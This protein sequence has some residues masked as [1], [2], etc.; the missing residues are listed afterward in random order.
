MLLFTACII[1]LAGCGKQTNIEENPPKEEVVE[2]MKEVIEEEPEPQISGNILINQIGYEPETQKLVIFRGERKELSFDVLDEKTNK[3]V[4]SDS[5]L[6]K[7]YNEKSEEYTSYGDFSKLTQTGEYYILVGKERS[8]TFSIQ[9]GIDQTLLQDQL[10]F[11]KHDKTSKNEETR[12][13]IVVDLLLTQEYFDQD[14]EILHETARKEIDEVLNSDKASG[15]TVAALAMFA[16]CYQDVDAT[17][18]AQCL[19]K[20]EEDWKRLDQS[21]V[22]ELYWPTAQLYKVTGK[23]VYQQMLQQCFDENVPEELGKSSDG[24]FGTLAYLTTTKKTNVEIC[25]TL[26]NALFDQAI[27]LI[28][29]S[30]KDGYKVALDEHY[31]TQSGSELVQNARLLTIMNIISKSKDYVLG[32]ENHVAYLGGRNPF[33][34]CYLN[35]EEQ[36]FQQESYVFILNGLIKAYE[37]EE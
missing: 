5:I 6:E 37:S 22:K 10:D 35:E 32:V 19:N 17:Y 16:E 29:L 30:S 2:V 11:F 14:N 27:D 9:E 34:L 12:S 7:E 36:L 31:S 1:C 25:T 13:L 20:A 4:Y 18:S 8:K 33:E 23:S 26:M 28:E 21:L 15:V 24:L 3:V